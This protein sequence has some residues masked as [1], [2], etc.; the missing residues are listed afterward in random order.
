MLKPNL[1]SP[2]LRDVTNPGVIKALAQLMREAQKDV[3]IGEGSAAADPNFRPG[4]FGSVCRTKDKGMLNDIQQTVFTRLGYSEL[5]K[6]IKTPLVNLHTGEMSKV[7]IPDGF[8][9]KEISLHH[10]L[11]KIDMLCSV[12]MMK[13]HGL[14][15]INRTKTD[16]WTSGKKAPIWKSANYD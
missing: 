8:V 13:T 12:P 7:G 3:S 4:I 5:S 1:V 9:F 14:A 15:T 11:T 2:E 6:S 16:S 10:S